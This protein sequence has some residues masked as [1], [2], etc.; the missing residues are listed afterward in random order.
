MKMSGYTLTVFHMSGFYMRTES[1]R[2]INRLKNAIGQKSNHL[3][4]DMTNLEASALGSAIA[5]RAVIT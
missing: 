1:T 5:S 3:S 4:N 2:Q